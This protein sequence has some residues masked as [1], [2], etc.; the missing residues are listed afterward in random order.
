MDDKL[1]IHLVIN[2]VKYDLNIPRGSEEIY[3]K[4]NSQ[5]NDKLMKYRKLFPDIDRESLWAISS[6]EL[7]FENISMT[8][9]NDTE[10]FIKNLKQWSKDID[11]CI[12]DK[13][14]GE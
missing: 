6:L 5:V 13:K 3:R 1:M 7:A 4:A 12:K 11:E 10:P 14:D 2:N 8:N 9:R